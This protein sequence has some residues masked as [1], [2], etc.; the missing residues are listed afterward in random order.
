MYIKNSDGDLVWSHAHR[1]EV[2]NWFSDQYRTAAER[3]ARRVEEYLHDRKSGVYMD[4]VFLDWAVSLFDRE[5]SGSGGYIPDYDPQRARQE[6]TKVGRSISVADVEVY[7]EDSLA[8]AYRKGYEHGQAANLDA[9]V[10][11]SEDE[12]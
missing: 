10:P 9:V 2:I 4:P 11:S 12:V 8:A 6:Q 7:P 3:L 1:D 5:K